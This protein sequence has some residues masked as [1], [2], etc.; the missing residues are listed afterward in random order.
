MSV[1]KSNLRTVLITGSQDYLPEHR[2]ER[3]C[4]IHGIKGGDLE[5]APFGVR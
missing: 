3:T 1:Y 2:K 5:K 4:K